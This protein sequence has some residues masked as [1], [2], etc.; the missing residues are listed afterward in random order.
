VS[1]G[2]GQR[3]DH[4]PPGHVRRGGL[5]LTEEEDRRLDE[6][7]ERV[8]RAQPLMTPERLAAT[9]RAL[10]ALRMLDAEDEVRHKKEQKRQR[11]TRA[12]DGGGAA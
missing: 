12:A 8:V 9:A 4:V 5:L 7:A 11:D 3:R 1:A 10:D 2:Q 6:W